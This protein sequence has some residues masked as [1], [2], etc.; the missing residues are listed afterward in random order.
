MDDPFKAKTRPVTPWM[1]TNKEQ[2]AADRLKFAEALLKTPTF[3]AKPLKKDFA[4]MLFCDESFFRVTD[5]RKVQWCRASQAPIARE[6]HDWSASAHIWGC[7]G[8]NF[9]CL[10]DF[11]N[12]GTGPRG[13]ITS[14]D[15]IRLLNEHFVPKFNAHKARYPGTNFLLVQ[16]GARI[17]T[18][19]ECLEAIKSWGLNVF[20]KKPSKKELK[21]KI[22]AGRQVFWF[23]PAH[24]PDFNPIENLWFM[25]KRSTSKECCWD[26]SASEAAKF[27]L[28]K[29]IAKY[30]ARLDMQKVTDLIL[31]FPRRLLACVKAKGGATGY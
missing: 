3:V 9:K 7:V 11:S 24:S 25:M 10:I 2:W 13:G 30:W 17:H 23:W 8:C 21:A 1:G 29:A 15:Y 20:N 14:E 31:S 12:Q 27:A 16:D 5:N 22:A 18:T 6:K 19:D 4:H 28:Y 26:L